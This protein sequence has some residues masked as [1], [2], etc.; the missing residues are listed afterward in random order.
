[1]STERAT[2]IEMIPI[3]QI[4]LVN[5]RSRG[6]KKFKQI[7]ENIA[8]LGLKKPI[9]VTPRKSR[10]SGPSYDLVCGQGR[11]EALQALGQKEVP[12]FVVQ[13]TKDELMLMSLA[14]NLARRN[15]TSHELMSSIAVLKD[16][17][18]THAEI[19]QKTALDI[20][21]VR[22]ILRLLSRGEERLLRA[23]DAQ[24]IPI[25]IAVTIAT[26]DDAE[27]QRVLAD[28]YAK[29]ALRGKELLRARRL[30]EQRRA[31]GKQLQNPHRHP[32]GDRGAETVLREY[33]R[34]TAR[35]QLQIKQSRVCEAK[36]QFLVASLRQLLAD[37]EF[38][39]IL[40]AE[41]LDA[42]PKN[43]SG[44]LDVQRKVAQ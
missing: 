34:E 9:T 40:R 11:L 29:D 6:P 14:E 20:S 27:V 2:Q 23:V 7:V 21:Y 33:E 12:A 26:A 44:F 41:G 5:P 32:N 36:F 35:Q 19:A 43:L 8:T 13:T 28:A 30:L 25:S 15:R 3:E 31:C 4:S 22:G 37:P 42:A 16:R 10:G 24:E 17:G 18:D 1:M 39:A 38:L